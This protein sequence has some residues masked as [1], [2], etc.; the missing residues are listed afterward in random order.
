MPPSG[1]TEVY[2]RSGGMCRHHLQDEREPSTLKTE[3]VGFFETLINANQLMR[4][5]IADVTTLC[6]CRYQNLNSQILS[7][8]FIYMGPCIVNR[9]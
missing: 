9:L 4:H 2:Q 3:V 6:T 5:H 8:F 1:L 7:L